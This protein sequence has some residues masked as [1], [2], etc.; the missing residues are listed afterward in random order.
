MAKRRREID[1]HGLHGG[2]VTW[3]ETQTE[4]PGSQL[5]HHLRL[6]GYHQRMARKGRHNGGAQSNVVRAERRRAAAA[7]A[8]PDFIRLVR[9]WG[10]VTLAYRKR[11]QDSPAYRLN[12]EEVSKAL[13]EGI[14]FA[15]NLDPVEAIRGPS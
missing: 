2:A 10:G 13:E 8:S 6:L 7:G 3:A 14:V 5:G 15:E 1:A 9:Q 11:M 12:H 4:A